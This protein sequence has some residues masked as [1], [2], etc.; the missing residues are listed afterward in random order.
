MLNVFS[1]CINVKTTQKQNTNK[2]KQKEKINDSKLAGP[3][4]NQKVLISNNQ[5]W[6]FTCG[7]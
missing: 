3:Y 5:V 7:I 6:Y 4:F 2:R 1:V